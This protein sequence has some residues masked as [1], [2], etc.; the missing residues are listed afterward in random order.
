MRRVLI[1]SLSILA[2]LAIAAG[3]GWGVLFHTQAGRG[4]IAHKLESALGGALGGE[5]EID[6]LSGDL[7]GGIVVENLILSDADGPWLTVERID[8]QWRPL[9]IL[10]KKI[11]VDELSVQ[12]ATLLRQP[13]KKEKQAQERG[14]VLKLPDNLPAVAITDFSI[15][16]FRSELE[17]A[18]TRLD[19]LGS[20]DMGGRRMKAQLALRSENDLDN[21]DIFINLDPDQDRFSL[22]AAVNAEPMGFIGALMQ[23]DDP[24]R[25]KVNGDGDV[26]DAHIAVD[27]V[28]GGFGAVNAEL[29]SNLRRP[30]S[31]NI[32]GRFEPGRRLADIEELSQPLAF[33]LR[34]EEQKRGGALAVNR[35]TSAVGEIKGEIGWRARR[36]IAEIFDVDIDASLAPDYRPDIQTLIGAEAGLKGTLERRD[37]DYL[38]NATL[39]AP[40]LQATL[41]NIATDLKASFVGDL[42]ASLS[43]NEIS[44]LLQSGATLLGRI[45]IDTKTLA[46]LREFTLTLGDES[47]AAGNASY[48]FTDKTIAFKGDAELAPALANALAPALKPA[49]PIDADIEASGAVDRF[50]LATKIDTPSIAIGDSKAPPLAIEIALAGLPNLPNGDIQARAKQ[51]PGRF[52]ATLRSSEAGDIAVN[53]L[54]YAGT[55]FSLE[56]GGH[57]DKDFKTLAVDLRYQGENGAE[58]WPAIILAGDLSVEGSF[59]RADGGADMTLAAN[60]LR[61]NDIAVSGLAA[62]AR[63]PAQAIAL[64]ITASQLNAGQTGPFS[65]LAANAILDTRD[66]AKLTLSTFKGVAVDNDFTLLAP[67]T[68]SFN[69]GVNIDALKLKWGEAGAIDV[70]A[71]ITPQRW[72]ANAKLQNVNI[73]GADGVVTLDLDLDT[74]TTPLAS[75]AFTLRSLLTDDEE[76]GVSGAFRWDGEHVV[77]VNA[78]EAEMIDMNI[79]LPARLIRQPALALDTDG[80]LDG[81]V[82]YDGRVEVI[83]AY[84]PPSLQSLEG[85]LKADVRLSGDVKTPEVTGKAAIADGAYTE[86]NTGFSLS[87]LHVDADADY[88][89][90]GGAV[91]FA[92]GAHGAGQ[93]G[94][95]T[96]TLDGRMN[97]KEQGDLALE[98]RLKN[99][100]LSA[101]PISSLHADGD[102]KIAGPF[103]AIAA[104]GAIAISE[105]N[106]EIVTPENTGLEPI[107]VVSI[108]DAKDQADIALSPPASTVDYKIGVKAD[109]RIFIRGRGLESEWSADVTAQNDR[110]APLITG[111]LNL[112]RGW[113]DFSGRRFSLTKGVI[114]FDRLSPN[115]PLLDMKAEYETGDGVTAII[116]IAGRAATP[117]IALESTPSKPQEDIMALILFGK[118]AEELSALESLQTAQALASLGGVGHFGGDGLTGALRQATGLD[119]LNVNLDPENGG[120]SLTVGKYVADG[121][122]VSATQDAQGKNG[123]VRV[124]YNITDNISVETEVQ[125]DG[126]QTVSANWKKDF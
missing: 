89:A 2:V 39:D 73:P 90:Q 57:A 70:A 64:S 95:D 55:G 67:A 36:K 20:L 101:H 74:D 126:E 60:A 68:F 103:S 49:G 81:H 110:G 3:C 84:L 18:K 99:A 108:D 46:N 4:F 17:A 62:K 19:A 66:G 40:L 8:L 5:A 69:D 102:I 9:S 87:G 24:V 23:L 83:A 92:G 105:L 13:P 85:A 34:L 86:L 123:S 21:A 61:V 52:S 121:L 29:A 58:P 25:L 77:L 119:L 41:R 15:A 116:A 104:S 51:G 112:K 96:I 76:T 114:D 32:T 56:G 54:S 100:A 80:P 94:D 117:T 59:S 7:P 82:R 107:T 125:Q 120:G 98:I 106:A 38:L 75:G 45:D 124:E 11:N 10:R 27:G 93:D 44:P 97:L 37:K 12:S 31:V 111:Q 28:I 48:S 42:N 47:S 115:N 14:L 35:L 63:G 72:R 43:A 113:L 71:A 16:N 26:D 78:P 33:D 109:D 65:D 91:S 6:S 50:T 22:D 30:D 118:P 122:F 79:V 1:I 88:N 53:D